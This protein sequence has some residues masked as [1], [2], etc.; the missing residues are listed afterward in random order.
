MDPLTAF[1][2]ACG[3][4]QVVDFSI[5][6]LSKC[7][8]IYQEGSLSDC[9]ELESMTKHL[10][11]VRAK[12]DLPNSKQGVQ[13]SDATLLEL[14]GH[15]SETADQLVSKLHSL[16]LDGPHKRRQAVLKAVRFLWERG[17]IQEIQKRLDGYRNAL[18]SQVLVDLRYV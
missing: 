6:A 9:K 14:A 12:L 16:K 15:C 18:D 8:E 1:S 4:I 17:E 7:K 2:L 13:A 10:I 11:D 5:K 3:V